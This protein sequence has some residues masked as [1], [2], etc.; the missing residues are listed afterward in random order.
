MEKANIYMGN[1]SGEF[2]SKGVCG[3]DFDLAG[4]RSF[5]HTHTHTHTHVFEIKFTFVK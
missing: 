1:V 5:T 3:G 2:I 4:K